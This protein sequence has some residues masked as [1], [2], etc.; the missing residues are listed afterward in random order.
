[1][2]TERRLARM[3]Q[4]LER[5]HDDLV[6]VLENIHDAHNAS[7]VLRSCDAFGVG[8]I[9]LVYTNQ[10]FPEISAGVAGKV[11]KWLRIDRFESV[12]ECVST[13]QGDGLNVYATVLSDDSRDYLEIDFS[14]PSAIVLGNEHAGCSAEMAARAD[15]RII[16]PM[17]GFAQS[18]NV[19]VAA[20]VVVAEIARQRRDFEPAWTTAKAELQQAWIERES[21][22]P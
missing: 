7:A 2:I 6:V 5:R 1:M 14:G 16:I 17:V 18:L 12:Q 3:R 4:V 9:A 10:V 21:A 20:A 15:G 11:E 13:L 8:R 22:Q 19:S